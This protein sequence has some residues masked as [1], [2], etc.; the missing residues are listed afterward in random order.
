MFCKRGLFAAASIIGRPLKLD[1]ATA[2]GSRLS[3]G[4]VCVEIDLLKPRVEDFWIGIGS[5][6]R[7]QKVVF[8]RLSKC[9]IQCLYLGHSDEECNFIGNQAIPVRRAVMQEL[10]KVGEDLRE[11]VNDEQVFEKSKKAVE[12]LGVIGSGMGLRHVLGKQE[13]IQKR[14]KAVIVETGPQ[15]WRRIM[16][17]NRWMSGVLMLR[18]RREI[19]GCRKRRLWG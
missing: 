11:Q 5:E 8:E 18:V 17:S 15:V 7:L 13:W 6:R 14:N 10:N 12:D 3:M 19:R 1:E 16:W 9:C 4:R 2:D